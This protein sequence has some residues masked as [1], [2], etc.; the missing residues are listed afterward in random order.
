MPSDSS[1]Q[2]TQFQFDGFYLPG[3]KGGPDRP[4][5]RLFVALHKYSACRQVD[6]LVDSGS[7]VT[8][9]QPRDSCMFLEESQFKQLGS[10]RLIQGI[11][12]T[13]TSYTEEGSI[14]FMLPDTRICW[15]PIVIDITDPKSGLSVYSTLGNDVLSYGTLS[16]NAIRRTV[17][18]V[19]DLPNPIIT[20]SQ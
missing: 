2:I 8:T 7:D 17:T 5:I 3:Y 19:L 13:V 4:F 1:S 11:G 6:M 15:I 20:E 16:L 14:G 9:L 10:P 18:I 12:G